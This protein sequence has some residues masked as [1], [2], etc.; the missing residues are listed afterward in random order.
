MLYYDRIDVS[1]GTDLA[2]SNNSKDCMICH[3][4][5]FNH[6]FNFQDYVCNGCH[7]LTMLS[8]NISDI[9]IITIEKIDYRCIIQITT[10]KIV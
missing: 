9:A 5:F 8:V 7:N 2:E 6:V 4:W 3:Y 10:A 1:K